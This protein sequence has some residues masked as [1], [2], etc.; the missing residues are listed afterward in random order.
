MEEWYKPDDEKL[1]G[2]HKVEPSR[3]QIRIEICESCEQL[4]FLKICKIC[5]CVM[6]I[7]TY[8]PFAE[9]PL[10]KW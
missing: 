3:R 4:S 9:C 6:P 8:I 7:K 5:H 1:A 10:G 2:E